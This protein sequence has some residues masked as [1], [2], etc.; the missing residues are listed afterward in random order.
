MTYFL[1]QHNVVTLGRKLKLWA[2]NGVVYVEDMTDGGVEA[3]HWR[4]AAER[5]AAVSDFNGRRIKNGSKRNTPEA[6]Y[7]PHLERDLEF[8]E[9][10]V[11]VIRQ[12]REQCTF[13]DGSMLRDRIR[14]MP[15]SVRVGATIP[16][17]NT[18]RLGEFPA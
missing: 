15:V 13:D 12:A 5:A 6:R 8:C 1:G 4:I 7:L 14:R 18:K 2:E 16:K 3:M 9:K 10:F 11:D 17:A